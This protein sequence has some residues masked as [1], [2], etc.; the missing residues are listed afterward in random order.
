MCV[1][2]SASNKTR[3]NSETT[4][5]SAAWFDSRTEGASLLNINC[6]SLPLCC[7]TVYL[8]VPLFYQLSASVSAHQVDEMRE[9]DFCEWR[10]TKK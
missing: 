8:R 3:E 7:D 2:P 9:K 10:Q 1:L 6:K 4:R 5:E